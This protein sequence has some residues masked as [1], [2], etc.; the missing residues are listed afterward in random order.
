MREVWR[1]LFLFVGVLLVC[2]PM[3]GMAVRSPESQGASSEARCLPSSPVGLIVR[4][5]GR[6]PVDVRWKPRRAAGEA[7]R[8]P[9]CLWKERRSGS[10]GRDWRR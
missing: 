4:L 2:V 10:G 7:D 5:L 8:A 6:L 3:Q 9:G 1:G